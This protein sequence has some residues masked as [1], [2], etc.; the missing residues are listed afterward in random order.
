MMTVSASFHRNV[1]LLTQLVEPN[2]DFKK[3]FREGM[4]DKPNTTGFLHISHYLLTIYDSDQ[5]QK[6]F[7]WP[8]ICKKTELKYRNSV[9]DYLTVISQENPDIGFPNILNSHLIHAGGSKFTIIMWKLSEVVVRRY[10]IRQSLVWKENINKQLN[11][12]Q[13]KNT[14]LKGIE[15][16]ISKINNIILSHSDDANILDIKNMNKINCSDISDLFCPDIQCL[17]FELYK[18]DKLV[19]NNFVVLFNYVM[20]QLYERLKLSTLEDYSDLSLQ[21]KASCVDLENASSVIQTYVEDVT[22]MTAETQDILRQRST[23]KIHDDALMP[24]M[25]NMLVTL[26]P[27]INIDTDHTDEKVDLQKR[28]QLTPMKAAHKSLFLRYERLKQYQTP[29]TSKFRE[30]LLVSR[31]NFDDTIASTNSDNRTLNIQTSYEKCVSAK[32]NILSFKQTEKYSRLFSNR[33]KRYGSKADLSLMSIPCSSKANST[34]IGNAI[35]EMN[36][37]EMNDEKMNDKEI[38]DSLDISAKSTEIAA[39]NLDTKSNDCENKSEMEDVVNEFLN[40]P[41]SLINE[42][43]DD[44]NGPKIPQTRQKRRSIGDLVERYKKLLGK[45]TAPSPD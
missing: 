36:D 27:L 10:I 9:K 45:G 21:M 33:M 18:D 39:P 30:H 12:L 16:L 22:K 38:E 26:S 5:F 24:I 1:Y 7:E 3:H 14:A 28:L 11:Y 25:N 35:E 19:F 20:T 40:K 15:Q 6:L 34:T 23:M 32:K 8:V 29:R 31:I 2:G 44:N 37:E 17:L 42:N 4:F 41:V 43:N 13:R